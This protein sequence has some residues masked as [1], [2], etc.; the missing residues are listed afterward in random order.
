MFILFQIK[1]YLS[2]VFDR[3]LQVLT[4]AITAALSAQTAA[5][6]AHILQDEINLAFN[7]VD[8]KAKLS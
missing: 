4:K 6:A 5:M 3:F 7:L 1:R 8:T 2:M